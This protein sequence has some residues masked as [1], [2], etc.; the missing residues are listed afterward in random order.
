MSL[1]DKE[2]KKKLCCILFTTPL[3]MTPWLD[4]RVMEDSTKSKRNPLRYAVRIVHFGESLPMVIDGLYHGDACELVEK[5][6]KKIE[7]NA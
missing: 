7:E 4:V 2:R 5:I 6:L 3:L 1:T